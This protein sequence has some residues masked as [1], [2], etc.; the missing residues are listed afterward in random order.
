M[1]TVHRIRNLYIRMFSN[2]H[3]PPHF[4]VETPDGRVQV[5]L[6][7]LSV[8]RGKIRTRDLEEIRVWAHENME[9]LMSEWSRLNEQ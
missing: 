5:A 8:T 9:L 4:H 1:P 6:L 3:N 7:D 2:E